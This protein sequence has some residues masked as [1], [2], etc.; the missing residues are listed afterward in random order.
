[1]NINPMKFMTLKGEI[2]RFQERHPKIFQFC[3]AMGQEALKEGTVIEIQV[4]T[5]EGKSYSS[6]LKLNQDDIRLI[7]ELKKEAQN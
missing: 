3:R 6:N 7:E 4:T 1:M 2:S 5:A